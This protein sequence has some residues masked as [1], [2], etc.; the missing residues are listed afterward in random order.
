MNSGN[1]TTSGNGSSATSISTTVPSAAAAAAY[2]AYYDPFYAQASSV[3]HGGWSAYGA[4]P[5]ST[6]SVAAAA[7]GSCLLN[8]TG[9]KGMSAHHGLTSHHFTP[10]H[11]QHQRRKRRV[12]FT[13]AQVSRDACPLKRS[14][15]DARSSRRVLSLGHPDSRAMT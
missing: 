9:Q 10:V 8:A 15:L 13:Q 5:I 6:S 12:L 14:A 3:S 11:H 2:Q 7:A 4:P 1:G